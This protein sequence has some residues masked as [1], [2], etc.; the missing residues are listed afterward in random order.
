MSFGVIASC[1]KNCSAKPV[2]TLAL[3]LEELATSSWQLMFNWSRNKLNMFWDYFDNWHLLTTVRAIPYC[4]HILEAVWCRYSVPDTSSKQR[5]VLQNST[6]FDLS[7]SCAQQSKHNLKV[8]LVKFPPWN[9]TRW[10]K[11]N[12]LFRVFDPP[13][14]ALT[15]AMYVGFLFPVSGWGKR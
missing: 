13:K 12:Q 8:D 15:A 4:Y 6:S 5:H 1:P 11:S 10:V 3:Q 2:D 7:R 9:A 14:L